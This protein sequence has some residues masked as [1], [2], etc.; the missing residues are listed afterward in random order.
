VTILRKIYGNSIVLATALRRRGIEYRNREKIERLRDRRVR[1]IVRYAARNVP[2]YREWFRESG[3][4][5]R[6][7]KT[8]ADLGRLPLLEK[9]TIIQDPERFRSESRRGRSAIK[10]NTSGSTGTPLTFYH[11]QRSILAN[12]AFSEPERLAKANFMSR[13]FGYRM[14]MIARSE[15]TGAKVRNFCSDRTLIP[16]GPQIDRMNVS[17]PP[18]KVIESI[19]KLKP[20]I[21]SGYGSYLELL[22]RYIHE[23]NIDIPLPQFILYGG[24][25]MTGPGRKLINEQFGLPVLAAYNAVECFKIGFQCGQDSAYHLHEDLCH[26]RIAGEKGETL[27][28]GEKGLVIIS[29]LVNR[30]T[31][32]LNYSLGDIASLSGEPCACGRSLRLLLDLEGRTEDMLILADGHF[33]HPRAV[34]AVLRTARG[35]LRYQLVQHE[36]QR[37]ELTLVTTDEDA[38]QE[39]VQKVSPEFQTLLGK[40]SWMRISR[41]EYLPPDHSGKF[42]PVISK[43]SR[44]NKP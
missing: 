24:D 18:E 17:D 31:V 23:R 22:F 44:G 32:L 9:A 34:W 39:I 25:G 10:F 38:Y 14:L 37:F 5:P 29:N 26:V 36:T 11:D 4:D 13:Q 19:R 43:C 6:E 33:L 7:I 28:A 41:Q 40:S 1:K 16:M 3:I 42:R 8:A 35:L 15:S 30:G 2:Y 27:A 21:L 20:A 12:I